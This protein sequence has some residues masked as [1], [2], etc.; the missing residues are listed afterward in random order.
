[1]QN[2][3]INYIVKHAGRQTNKEIHYG[4]Y[5]ASNKNKGTQASTIMIFVNANKM[6]FESFI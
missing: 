1:M 6:C 3:H 4:L 2:R 5:K